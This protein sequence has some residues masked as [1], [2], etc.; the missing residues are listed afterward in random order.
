[1][2]RREQCDIM[3]KLGATLAQRLDQPYFQCDEEVF[4]YSWRRGSAAITVTIRPHDDTPPYL[5]ARVESG[6]QPDTFYLKFYPTDGTLVGLMSARINNRWH[7]SAVALMEGWPTDLHP[8]LR[9][10]FVALCEELDTLR[11]PA[12]G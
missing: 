5:W 4:L 12:A 11:Q 10:I 9:E 8:K 7:T 1:M 6:G 3:L 2:T